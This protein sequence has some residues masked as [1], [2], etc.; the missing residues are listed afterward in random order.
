MKLD[1]NGQTVPLPA[2]AMPKMVSEQVRERIDLEEFTPAVDDRAGEGGMTVA[3]A[4]PSKEQSVVE[5][6][7]TSVGQRDVLPA[8]QVSGQLKALQNELQLTDVNEVAMEEPPA[9]SASPAA[10]GEVKLDTALAQKTVAVEFKQ[11]G[12]VE[13]KAVGE[14]PSGSEIVRALAGSGADTPVK[15]GGG[16]ASATRTAA[17]TR[18]GGPGEVVAFRQPTG[19]DVPVDGFE[20]EA[21]AYG[22]N[23]PGATNAP[24]AG[25]TAW[26]SG[27]SGSFDPGGG[28]T[29]VGSSFQSGG[30]LGDSGISE[31]APAKTG[32]GAD[33]V[34]GG[35][36]AIAGDAESAVGRSGR[37]HTANTGGDVPG[38]TRQRLPA[39]AGEG[40]P[41]DAI[42]TA[43]AKRGGVRPG[44]LRLGIPIEL[45]APAEYAS[46][47]VP[48]LV[49]FA[50]RPT[51]E[52]VEALGG[53]GETEAAIR[54][55]LEWLTRNQE[56]D[57]RWACE[58]QGGEAG[59]DV[60]ATA[61]ALLCYYGW[62]MKHNVDCEY[63][64]PVKSGMAWLLG[65]IKPDGDIRSG[66]GKNGMYDQGIAGMAL[67]EAYG[68]SRDPALLLPSSNVV[69]FIA[70]AQNKEGGWRYQPDS[71]DTDM[72]VFGWQFMALHSARMSGIPCPSNALDR[73]IAWLDRVSGGQSGGVYGYQS[74]N[75]TGRPA[76]SACGM[77]CRQLQKIPPTDARM[78]E[79]AGFLRTR[80]LPGS[81]VDFYY[82]YY[83]TLAL[84][85][86][87]GEVW[88]EWNQRVKEVLPPLQ[89]KTGSEAGSWD[90][91]GQYGGQ[92]GR[93]ISTAMGTL[94]LEVYYR[95]LP[96]YGYRS[97][98]DEGRKGQEKGREGKRHD[99]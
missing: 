66:N 44:D 80:S 24:G 77:F 97:A 37:D 3:A 84:Y 78:K 17:A 29:K 82:L 59:H 8:V 64:K 33:D 68:I 50:G 4:P 46:R 42:L 10:A 18:P 6:V 15:D 83:T 41:M 5:A 19:Y 38:I 81:N 30:G 26:G 22:Q 51:L 75:E 88:E 98:E 12:P 94:S 79:T 73:A 57:G 93:C 2:E 71:Q 28:V 67:C 52:V 35:G 27:V 69:A 7:P 87:Q 21:P 56:P 40:E 72:S 49:V 1:Q 39:G 65:Q 23:L 34:V 47:R 48:D 60:A 36:V 20:M 61:M 58:K 62:G 55:S 86:H 91:Q 74:P 90:P 31:G 9:G 85:Q 43:L 95:F 99:K 89:R 70:R 76:M 53:S 25:A 13:T 96:M 14:T 92:M 32:T 11:S 54:G 45:E 16:V 63:L